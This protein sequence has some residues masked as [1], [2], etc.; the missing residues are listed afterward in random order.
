MGWGERIIMLAGGLPPA[1]ALMA[2]SS[3]LPKIDAALA[4]GPQDSFLVKQL[5][6]AVGLAMVVGAPLAG[7]LANRFSPRAILLPALLVY[8]VAGTTGLYLNELH[9]L[10]IARLCV[11][12][13]AAAIQIISMTLINTRLNENDRARWMGLHIATA[14][15][16]TILVHP[17]VGLLGEWGWRWPFAIYAAGLLL[18]PAVLCAPSLTRNDVVTP[19]AAAVA[20]NGIAELLSWFPWRYLLLA[21]T[22][23]SIAYLPIVYTPYLLRNIGVTSSTVIAMI[24]TADS[25][26]GAG[27]AMFYGRARRRLSHLSVFIVSFASAGAGALIAQASTTIVGVAVGLIVFGFGIGWFVPNLMTALATQVTPQRQGSAVGLVKAAHFLSAPLAITLAEPIG[28]QYGPA[29]VLLVVAAI[30]L[31]ALLI[32]AV[33]ARGR[34]FSLPVASNIK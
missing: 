2:L 1:L 4:H 29:G 7:F 34:L 27:M 6:G 31:F 22:M 11:G 20:R 12:V 30:A 17:I 25:L 15:L 33:G 3:V 13:T 18:L 21:M 8:I 9:L 14:M 5:I 24:L 19:S 16:G 26:A 32:V 10:L 28:R 23:G